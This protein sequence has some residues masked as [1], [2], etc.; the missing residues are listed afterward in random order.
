MFLY[1]G[2]QQTG[3]M[4]IAGAG[5][6]EAT[7]MEAQMTTTTDTNND[8]TATM[9]AAVFVE[10]EHMEVRDVPRPKIEKPTDA[11]VRVLKACVCGSDL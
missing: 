8:T 7:T 6:T 11:I 3:S 4:P 10:P 5:S 1:R 2:W 9:K